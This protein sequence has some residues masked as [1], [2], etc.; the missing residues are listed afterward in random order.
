MSKERFIV[1]PSTELPV[2]I[3]TPSTIA[4]AVSAVRS[5]RARRPRNV[6]RLISPLP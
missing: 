1:A 5:L 2:T 4:N 6:T 3:A